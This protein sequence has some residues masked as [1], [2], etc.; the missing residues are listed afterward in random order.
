[1]IPFALPP[2][3]TK[4]SLRAL[5]QGFLSHSSDF[6][7]KLQALLG[8]K[9]CVLANSAR[10]LLYLLFQDLRNRSAS[11]GGEVLVPGYTCYSVPAALVKAGLQV[12]LYDID[13]RSLQPDMADV[14]RKIKTNTLAIVVQQLLGVPANIGELSKIA[15]QHG[16]C[17]IEDSAQL[18]GP[19]QNIA[20]K[21][22]AAD[23]TVFSFGRGKPLP[24]GNG[25]ALIAK[26]PDDL[27]RLAR[28]LKAR[29]GKQGISFLP[30]AVQILAMP[31]FY[32][33]VEKLPLG[34]GRTVYDPSFDVTDMPQLYQRFGA[35]TL[36]ELVL[37]NLHRSDIAEIYHSYL[38]DKKDSRLTGN[39]PACVRY[40]LLVQNQ[41]A[42]QRLARYGVRQ[43]YPLALC[44][45]LPLR[46]RLAGNA[47]MTPGAREIANR[48]ITLPTHS[49]VNEKT[50]SQLVREV[51]QIF[52]QKTV[53]DFG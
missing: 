33:I 45:L 14:K 27:T 8:T 28:D 12:A 41:G 21:E 29:P 34:L 51:E 47:E 42:A 36:D 6:S 5:T 38:S 25:G 43:F 53:I 24:L 4:L 2:A 31:H 18:L 48:L 40:P 19:F 49:A 11:N 44:D 20:G 1:M 3:E 7:K 46:H 9:V 52:Q 15:R 39:M 17:C 23:F 32:W 22:M 26:K 35:A 50:A 16:I 30:F 37:L 13:P 10:A